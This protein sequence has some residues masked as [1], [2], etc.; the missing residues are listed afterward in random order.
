MTM[1]GANLIRKAQQQQSRNRQQQ[2]QELLRHM[3][4]E[5]NQN[6]HLMRNMQ[7]N[8]GINLNMAMKPGQNPLPRAAMANSQNKYALLFLTLTCCEC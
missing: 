5:M 1:W 7:Q 3:R 6:F 8:G 4:P 2:Q